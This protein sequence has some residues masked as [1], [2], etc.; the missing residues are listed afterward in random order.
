ME[1]QDNLKLKEAKWNELLAAGEKLE[2]DISDIAKL[3]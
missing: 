1:L 3:P 2:E